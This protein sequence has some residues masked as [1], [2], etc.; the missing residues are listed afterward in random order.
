MHHVEIEL[1]F[2]TSCQQ[3]LGLE[4]EILWEARSAPTLEF[5]HILCIGG[6]FKICFCCYVK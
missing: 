2:D 6:I 4:S 5:L 1:N 3:I